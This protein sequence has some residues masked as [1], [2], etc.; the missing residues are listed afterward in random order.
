MKVSVRWGAYYY[1]KS[2]LKPFEIL[3]I[4]GI[5][6]NDKVMGKVGFAVTIF[7]LF[8][9]LTVLREGNE[10]EGKSCER[11]E[12]LLTFVQYLIYY[13][14]LRCQQMKKRG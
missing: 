13:F 1:L 11:R 3:K 10:T 12:L 14:Y 7:F 2:Y 8:L 6:K 5:G 9:F 4:G